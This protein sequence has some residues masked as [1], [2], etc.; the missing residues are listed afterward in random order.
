MRAIYIFD[1]SIK[2]LMYFFLQSDS[3]VAVGPPRRRRNHFIQSIKIFRKLISYLSWYLWP[4]L[5]LSSF[6]ARANLLIDE[7]NKPEE[8]LLESLMS[9]IHVFST[10]CCR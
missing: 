9:I 7:L 2:F 8:T 10:F 4:A 6:M 5:F 3:F 1:F